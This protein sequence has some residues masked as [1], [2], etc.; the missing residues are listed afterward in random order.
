MEP[1]DDIGIL[2]VREHGK[3]YV[4][5]KNNSVTPAF[6]HLKHCDHLPSCVPTFNH[7]S[8]PHDLRCSSLFDLCLMYVS[9]N[10][11]NV[12]SLVGLPDVIG[13]NIFAAVRNQKVLQT[14]TDHV[15]SLVLQTF[16]KAYRNSLLDELSVGSLAV[17]D[18]HIESFS[19]FCHITKLG[20]SGCMLGDNHDYLLHIG[21]LSL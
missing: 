18:Q 21:H 6:K 16:D 8:C 13:E 11:E 19:A 12:D 9:T 3:L 7:V 15:C 10:I 1:T 17:L 20:I 2:Y 14:F 4:S 5:T